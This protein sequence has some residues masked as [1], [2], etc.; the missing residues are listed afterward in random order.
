MG[1]SL[2]TAVAVI[3]LNAPFSALRIVEQDHRL[4]IVKRDA[5]RDSPAA[6]L[7]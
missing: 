4:A 2:S 3:N 7:R 5:R 1:A 6:P